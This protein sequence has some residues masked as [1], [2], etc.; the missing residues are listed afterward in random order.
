MI[1]KPASNKQMTLSV[2]MALCQKV[3]D[4]Y[5][6]IPVGAYDLEYALEI[7][8]FSLL[9]EMKLRVISPEQAFLP[10]KEVTLEDKEEESSETKFLV[11]LS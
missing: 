11:F 5:G 8:E 7:S 2:L 6:D 4:K 9:Q 1:S 3:F 10:G